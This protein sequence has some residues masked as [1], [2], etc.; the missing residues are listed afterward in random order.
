MLIGAL[1]VFA[2][3]QCLHGECPWPSAQA[4]LA[5][6]NAYKAPRDKLACVVRCCETIENLVCLST[7]TASADNITPVL[8]FVVIKVSWLCDSAAT[9]TL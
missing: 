5:I 4:E 9:V 7:S 1:P 3:V 6:I 2:V 8:V